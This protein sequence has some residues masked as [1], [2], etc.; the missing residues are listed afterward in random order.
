MVAAN[1]SKKEKAASKEPFVFSGFEKS[2]T[3]NL[4]FA[5]ENCGLEVVGRCLLCFEL[6]VI[7]FRLMLI[8]SAKRRH[9]LSPQEVMFSR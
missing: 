5:F 7:F 9:F 1:N 6:R 2:Y 3:M 4:L 8:S